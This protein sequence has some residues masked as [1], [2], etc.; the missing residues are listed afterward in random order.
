MISISRFLIGIWT[1]TFLCFRPS[2]FGEKYNVEV[3]IVFAIVTFFIFIQNH[4]RKTSV[5]VKPFVV[6]GLILSLV[7]YLFIQGL[8]LGSSAKTVFN[9]CFLITFVSLFALYVTSHY[10]EQV[11]KNIVAIHFFL[12]VS[13]I[14]TILIFILS[15]FTRKGLFVVLNLNQFVGREAHVFEDFYNNHFLYFPLSVS[16]A[17]VGFAGISLPRLLGI[18]REAGMAQIFFFTSYFLTY[19]VSIKREKLVRT[20]LLMGGILTFSTSGLLSFL[21]GFLILRYFPSQR[22]RL[23]LTRISVLLFA[24]P[25]FILG[26]LFLPDIG[27]MNKVSSISGDQRTQSYIYSWNKFAERPLFGHGYYKGFEQME[28]QKD[29]VQFLGLIGVSYQIGIIGIILYLLPWI[30]SI[31]NLHS[32]KTY[33]ILVPCLIT[34]L[35][36]QPSYNDMFVWFL[37]LINF[38]KIYLKEQSLS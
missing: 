32:R 34:L 23:T 4:Y 8:L 36:S 25:L 31:S 29:Y 5:E 1:I 18:Y 30:Y 14:I 35:L 24:I 2:I 11:L 6:Y 13:S 17:N 38:K 22:I 12:S 7:C 3:F 19:I 28:V 37:L 15:G 26:A 10:G 16:W 9:S 27:L 20:V 33:F 21:T